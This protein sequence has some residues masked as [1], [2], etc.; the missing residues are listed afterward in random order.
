MGGWVLGPVVWAVA[1]DRL[2]SRHRDATFPL[3]PEDLREVDEVVQDLEESLT[4]QEDPAQLSLFG[5]TDLETL[6]VV[7]CEACEEGTIIDPNGC[8]PR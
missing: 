7:S 1:S 3:S 4:R 6:P 2:M 5:G 8:S